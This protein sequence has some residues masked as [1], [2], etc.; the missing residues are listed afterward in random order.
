M[1]IPDQP[2]FQDLIPKFMHLLFAAGDRVALAHTDADGNWSNTALD[3]DQAIAYL[4]ANAATPNLCFRAS[5]VD[6]K[7]Y[8]EANCVSA[9]AFFIDIDYGKMGHSK[10]STFKTLDDA[11]GYVLTM[12]IRPSVCWHTG[13]GLQAAYLLDRPLMFPAGDG[14]TAEALRRYKTIGSC[15]RKM[16][17]AD[18]AFTPEHA[19]RVPATINSKAHKYPAL[20]DTVGAMLWCD[21]QSLYTLAQIEAAC[22]GYGIEDKTK[23]GGSE[24]APAPV[25]GAGVDADYASL[26]QALRDEIE[27]TG[28]ERSDRC[29]S[30]IGA[31]AR[32]GY[33]DTVI[34]DAISHG[35]DFVEK[36]GSRDRGGGGG[37]ER[38]VRNCIAKIRGGRYVYS[39][40]S[41]PP[42]LIYNVAL[43][44][45]LS[46]CPPL[47]LAL[48]ATLA[49]YAVAAG[50][51]LAPR[52]RDAARFHEHLHS[53]HTAGVIESP[54]GAGKSVWALCHIAAHATADGAG[55]V[56]VTETVDAL[57]RAADMLSKLTQ[58]PVGR[59]HGF[60]AA[61][62]KALCGNDYTWKQCGRN[63]PKSKCVTCTVSA[64][65]SYFTRAE[66]I[67]CPI[68]CMTHSG[69]IRAMEDG[70][71][72]LHDAH[73]IIDE[74]LN[75]FDTWQVDVEDLL[76]LQR[77]LGGS[78][79][80]LG[81]LFPGSGLACNTSL[82]KW[83]ID[84][85]ANTF[86]RRNYVFR[87]ET[88]TAA[89]GP[90]IAE[91]HK[92]ARAGFRP[93]TGLRVSAESADAAGD[94]LSGLSNFFRTS[95]RGDACYAYRESK[96]A[97]GWV[98]SVTRSRFDFGVEGQWKSLWMLNASAGLTPHQYPDL[99]PVYSCPDLPDN[100]GLV[101][102]HVARANPTRTR[103]EQ[104]C[105]L[106]QL[107]MRFGET[108]RKHKRVLVA[109]DKGSELGADI[110]AR[111]KARCGSDCEVK[112]LTR[113]RIKGVNTC[114]DCTL[115]HL[116]AMAT[117]TGIDDCALHA[118]I[119]YRKTFPDTPDVYT[120]DG[121]PN[122]PGGRM[123]VPAMRNY[124]ALRSLD[125]I[126]QAIWRTSVRND[127]PVEAVVV[128]PD[129]HWLT[130]LWR[131]VMP[132]FKL[133]SAYV[134]KG[135]TQT[136]TVGDQAHEMK[137][138]FEY[139]DAMAGLKIVGMS[140]GQE[141]TKTMVASQLGYKE[142]EKNKASIMGL[143]G[144][145]FEDGSTNR[146]LRRKGT[147]TLP[148]EALAQVLGAEPK[149]KRVRRK[150]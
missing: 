2:Q 109:T 95:A 139:D 66:Q 59:L 14:G 21:A 1:R 42:V 79:G 58:V 48:E 36:Y 94:T 71:N 117:F 74:G 43:A 124:Y 11:I 47:P 103:Q 35:P 96:T 149:P 100:S 135:G 46:E 53:T 140:A 150:A 4:L 63:D 57:Y 50:I 22:A 88:Q 102:V 16:A 73:V 32:A 115:I 84:D 110:I 148:P 123:K 51:T 3:M 106:S 49:G 75:P 31:M 111:I 98:M 114:G 26:P 91:L 38:E 97:G 147:P 34:A 104:A 76:R 134:E 23:G 9:R 129:P 29:F 67:R 125:E 107:V 138:D 108:M 18:A 68:L 143:L 131:T 128:V 82:K 101:T 40:E 20:P 6:G 41:S 81:Q 7:G 86:S 69:F 133:E 37:L 127:E 90:V 118:C 52:V 44:V 121:G 24:P 92:L 10:T 15:L 65:C 119:Q 77:M 78:S 55:Y 145:F 13:H 28:S 5:S 146:L 33:S 8:A 30:V 93:D 112:V 144:D 60:N 122:W 62:C 87:D 141:I 137:W 130:A 56:Y 54:C 126:Y 113:G 136:I 45:G 27:A 17:L 19:Y 142:W 61:R 70:S 132:R 99:V 89:L 12:P 120:V 83:E 85:D 72:L 64:L 39:S 80:L 116:G 25:Q 105:R